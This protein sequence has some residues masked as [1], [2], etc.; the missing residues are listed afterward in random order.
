MPSNAVHGMRG[1]AELCG[2]GSFAAGMPRT[3]VDHAM[4]DYSDASD[5]SEVMRMPHRSH[6]VGLGCRI[7]PQASSGNAVAAAARGLLSSS[8]LAKGTA[9]ADNV[10]VLGALGTRLASTPCSVRVAMLCDRT[11]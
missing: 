1:Y 3:R 2:H 5:A 8:R 4:P 7:S 10:G 6:C 11:R 9:V